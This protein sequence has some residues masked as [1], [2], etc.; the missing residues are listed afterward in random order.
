MTQPTTPLISDKTRWMEIIA[1]LVTVTGKFIFMDMLNWRLV[2]II[3]II[4][5]WSAYVFYRSRK[6][7][8]TLHHWGF[9]TDNFKTVMWMVLPY[10]FVAVIGM[11]AIGYYL[12]TLNLQWHMIVILLLYPIWGIVQQFLVIAIIAGNLRDLK[13]KKLNQTVIIFITALLFG[14]IHYPWN[15]LM[16]ATFLLALFYGYIYLRERNLF[17][18]GIFHGWLGAIVFYTV[19]NRDPWVEVFG[20]MMNK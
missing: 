15:W 9:R 20:R 19:V 14:L 5:T 1:V 13:T 16:L 2:F 12:G 10:A 8:G 6:T 18:L 4:I 7:D 17:V 11:I 3:S